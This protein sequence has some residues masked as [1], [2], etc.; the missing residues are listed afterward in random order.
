MDLS[1]RTCTLLIR[2]NNKIVRSKFICLPE[3]RVNKAIQLY[4]FVLIRLH[5]QHKQSLINSHLDRKFD[6]ELK[7]NLLSWRRP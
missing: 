1:V 5:K 4:N 7:V 3:I 2:L 6:N